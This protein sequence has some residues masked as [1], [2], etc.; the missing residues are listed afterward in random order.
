M[1]VRKVLPVIPMID[2]L[3]D[4]IRAIADCTVLPPVGPLQISQAGCLVPEDLDRFFQVCGGI[5]FRENDPMTRFRIRGSKEVLPATPIIRGNLYLQSP[6]EYDND[7][8]HFWYLL[9]NE[10]AEE[11]LVIDFHPDRLGR[12]Y[13]GYIGTY[14]SSD[15]RIIALSFTDL[16]KGFIEWD[17]QWAKWDLDKMDALGYAY[18]GLDIE[19][20]C[21]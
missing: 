13:D 11:N 18:E 20:P 17:G 7:I 8:S 3:V 2:E 14:A 12:C 5:R 9:G 16:L 10:G 1:A 4:S 19:P 6:V 21:G 15:C